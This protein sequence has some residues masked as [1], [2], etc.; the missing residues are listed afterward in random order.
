M[1][2]TRDDAADMDDLASTFLWEVQQLGLDY[3]RTPEGRGIR[4]A[5]AMRA[6]VRQHLTDDSRRVRVMVALRR[7]G[8]AS[9]GLR[10]FRETWPTLPKDLRRQIAERAVSM[11]D[12]ETDGADGRP[13]TP[14]PRPREPGNSGAAILVPPMAALLGGLYLVADFQAD[15]AVAL[16]AVAVGLVVLALVGMLIVVL[17]GRG[18][19]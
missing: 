5:W 11:H 1:D 19:P 2:E 4:R 8:V 16:G 6:W 18:H 13:E 7:R 17:G 15:G 12:A 9:P 10:Y 14:H 3:A